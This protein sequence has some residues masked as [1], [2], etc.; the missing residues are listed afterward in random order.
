MISNDLVVRFEGR[1]LQLKP[2]RNQGLGA[3]ARVTVQQARDGELRVVFEG[4]TVAFDEIAKP[5]PKVRPEPKPRLA[6]RPRTP[7]ANHPWRAPF[8][9]EKTG[10]DRVKRAVEMTGPWK[11]EENPRQPTR[12]FEPHRSGFP[13]FPQPLG[14][15]CAIPTFPQAPTTTIPLLKRGHF[16]RANQ[17]DISIGP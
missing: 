17:G 9:A 10:G 6:P 16:Y 4:R 15:R 1:F 12:S 3:S 8:E 7:P 14:N 13:R 5:L 2:Q 11:N